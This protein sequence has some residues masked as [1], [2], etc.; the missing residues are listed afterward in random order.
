M[1]KLRLLH[2]QFGSRYLFQVFI[3]RI[4]SPIKKSNSFYILVIENH[5]PQT[6]SSD[7]ELIEQGMEDLF[8]QEN[9]HC[10]ND[11]KRQLKTF[12]LDETFA[13]VVKK[14]GKVAGWGFVQRSGVSMYAGNS[15]HIPKYTHLLKNLFVEPE[16]RG[17][18]IGKTINRARINC[19]PEKTTPTVFVIPSNKFAIRNLEMYGFEKQVYVKNTL[20]LN[21]YTKRKIKLLKQGNVALTIE[22]GLRNGK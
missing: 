21:K 4:V 17:Q 19:I 11:L 1:K 2:K 8:I 7:V 9:D 6:L 20:W 3:K 12:L 16:Y 13:V 5:I 14:K 15:Y 22:K 10:S 18:S